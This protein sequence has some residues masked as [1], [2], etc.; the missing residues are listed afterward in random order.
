MT[1]LLFST[2]FVI[3]CICKLNEW[4]VSFFIPGISYKIHF[5]NSFNNMSL[6]HWVLSHFIMIIET[7]DI[8]S[9]ILV[10]LMLAKKP[11]FMSFFFFFVVVVISTVKYFWDF[12]VL[13]CKKAYLVVAF[14]TFVIIW[15]VWAS[16]FVLLLLWLLLSLLYWSDI[17]PVF[18]CLSII[19]ALLVWDFIYIL[20][21]CFTRFFQDNRCIFCWF[22]KSLFIVK[23]GRKW[24]LNCHL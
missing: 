6:I 9:V 7:V 21:F 2:V 11:F 12:E 15:Q 13:L 20:L 16:H 1:I 8:F 4:S 5:Y 17:K 18:K 22:I 10:I 19:M 23:F 24:Q 3:F 14:N